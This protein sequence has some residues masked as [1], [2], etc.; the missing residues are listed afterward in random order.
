MAILALGGSFPVIYN[1]AH[2]ATCLD[3][4]VYWIKKEHQVSKVPTVCVGEKSA[5]TRREPDLAIGAFFNCS[6]PEKLFGQRSR[7]RQTR[8]AGYANR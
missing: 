5:L 7:S 6:T 8:Q 3:Q 4:F 1:W 2:I